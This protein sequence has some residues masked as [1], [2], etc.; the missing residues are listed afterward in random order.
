MREQVKDKGR[1]E[2][3]L[4]AIN[5]ALDFIG[6]V[7]FEEYQTNTILRFAVVKCVEIVGEASYKLTNEFRE[8]HFEIEW[9]NIISMRHIL[10]HGYYQTEDKI[11]WDTVKNYLPILKEQIQAIYENEFLR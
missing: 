6:N 2:H 3:I 7:S 11:V 4:E 8:Q 9:R 1:L 5:N 10:V